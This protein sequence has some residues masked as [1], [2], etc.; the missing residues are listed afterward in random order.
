MKQNEVLMNFLTTRRNPVCMQLTH[1][2][3]KHSHTVTH[4]FI[5]FMRN[6]SHQ[7]LMPTSQKHECRLIH[8]P[9]N[10]ISSNEFGCGSAAEPW[11]GVMMDKERVRQWTA[12]TLLMTDLEMS[13][14]TPDPGHLTFWVMALVQKEQANLAHTHIPI[15]RVD[16]R[17]FHFTLALTAIRD[18]YIQMTFQLDNMYDL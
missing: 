7:P 17:A 15:S 2:I 10:S 12:W 11:D 5:T 6:P 13:K 9:C 16:R 8:M 18:W 1:K 14:Q 4:T 3:Q